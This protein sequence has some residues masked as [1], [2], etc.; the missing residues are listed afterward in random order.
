V[1]IFEVRACILKTHQHG[2]ISHFDSRLIC[3]H[4][5]FELLRFLCQARAISRDTT[6]KSLVRVGAAA[7]R[8][9]DSR[10]VV[11]NAP[12]DAMS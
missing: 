11:I 8:R 5:P 12:S 9:R 6:E 10:T 2:I 7:S 1:R 3:G 4:A